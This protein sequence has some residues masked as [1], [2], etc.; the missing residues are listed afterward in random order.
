[1]ST[2]NRY[3]FLIKNIKGLNKQSFN[4]QVII[5]DASNYK[6]F[7]KLS[8][9]L[10]LNK[11]L[12]NFKFLHLKHENLSIH[13]SIKKSLKYIKYEYCT[14]L[15]DDDFI[16]VEKL[17]KFKKFL[18]KNKNYSCCGGK[19]LYFFENKN[20]NHFTSE[21][22]LTSKDSNN[23]FE[24]VR[25][26]LRNYEV[27]HYTIGRT[28]DFKN[29]YSLI[30]SKINKGIGCEL[31][32]CAYLCALGKVKIFNDL[33]L[34]RY[35]HDKR[36]LLNKTLD[37]F[38]FENW[39]FSITFLINKIYHKLLNKKNKNKKATTTLYNNLKNEF[40]NFYLNGIVRQRKKHK[41]KKFLEFLKFILFFCLGKKNFLRISYFFKESFKINSNFSIFKILLGYSSYSKDFNKVRKF[42]NIQI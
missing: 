33:F 11:N 37:Q 22:K 14:W 10:N 41:N 2:F 5:C 8:D 19:G 4:G 38:F 30:P 40:Q 7:K 23:S 29:R 34:I 12:F 31:F 21:F 16:L 32:G 42:Y 26:L 17:N 1:M 36:V 13:D 20:G 35:I 24:R 28:V 9:F 39:S 25:S 3:D 15:P 6:N 18:D 27:I